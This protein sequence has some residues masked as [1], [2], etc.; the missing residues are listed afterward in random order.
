MCVFANS[1]GGMLYIGVYDKGNAV[2]VDNPEDLLELI[3]N[4]IADTITILPKVSLIKKNRKEGNH[5]EKVRKSK[6]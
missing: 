3:P 5:Y 2:G 6:Y 1:D 4:K